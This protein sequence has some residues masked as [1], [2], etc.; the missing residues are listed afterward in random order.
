MA[1]K[2]S[3]AETPNTQP[4]H[5]ALDVRLIH[6]SGIGTYVK[7]L[8]RGFAEL[9]ENVVWS[10]IGPECDIP[11]GLKIERWIPF[12]APLYSLREF[13]S[14]PAIPGADVYHYPHYNLP[15]ARCPRR[16]VTVHDL[17]H[18]R[19]GSWPKGV[20]QKLF[21]RRL[22]WVRAHVLCDSDKVAEEIAQAI[23]SGRNRIATVP[24]GP[25]RPLPPSFSRKNPARLELPGGMKLAPP[26]LV[27]AG[28]DQPHKNM[29]FL[30]G[31][32]G[33]WYRRRPTA[34]PLV[35]VGPSA[36]QAEKRLASLP[37]HS[38]A[39]IQILPYSEEM[40]EPL[41]AGAAGL[42]FPSLD[43]GFGFPPFEAMAR[44]VPVVCSRMRP[45]IDQLGKAALWFEPRD[46]AT[47]WRA[48]DSL[49]DDATLRTSLI[50]EGLQQVA[51]YSWPRTAQ[52][53][54]AVYRGMMG[55]ATAT[56]PVTPE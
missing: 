21:L 33:L 50:Q 27:A 38:R 47:L 39:K 48:L 15:R 22:G 51:K 42:V 52:E 41:F 37:A 19:Y 44:G 46:S 2:S 1:R 4:L 32:M 56:P 29:E 31:A 40:M 24:L 20:Y 34:P 30:L 16:V 12:D 11:A 9:D 25:G 8:L 5:V 28:I 45:M 7:G 35:W 23:P 55:P 6:N 14:Y 3:L 36:E 18:I 53:T 17:F 10:F 26:W 49:L 54:L 13:W 43:E